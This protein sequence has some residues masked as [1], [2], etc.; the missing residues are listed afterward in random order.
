M[1]L[2]RMPSELAMVLRQIPHASSVSGRATFRGDAT[3]GVHHE[4]VA[5]AEKRAGLGFLGF[6]APPILRLRAA[7]DEPP[8]HT[9]SA[10]DCCGPSN[11]AH[12][13]HVCLVR[14]VVQLEAAD[15]P[16]PGAQRWED[17]R[18]NTLKPFGGW[19]A[20]ACA[21]SWLITSRRHDACPLRGCADA[22]GEP[23]PDDMRHYVDCRFV[24]AASDVV[25]GDL[26]RSPED[27][28]GLGDVDET[29]RIGRFIGAYSKYHSVKVP[30]AAALPPGE[31]RGAVTTLDELCGHARL[32]A[33]RLP[34]RRRVQAAL[35]Q[36]RG[37]A[38]G[39]ARLADEWT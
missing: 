3:R 35:E 12:S 16:G 19:G 9:L 39:R 28:F 13:A 34:Q 30:Q 24:R 2:L 17:I 6:P 20:L 26:G 36:V 7:H 1:Y 18:C 33:D 5:V 37:R 15:V 14:C 10:S 23:A 8:S 21:K 25:G 29:G 38:R 11:L 32:A 4:S 22:P 27:R 31:R